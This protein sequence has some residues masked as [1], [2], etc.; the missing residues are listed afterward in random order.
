MITKFVHYLKKRSSEKHVFDILKSN[1]SRIAVRTYVHETSGLLLN[2][3][4]RCG[5]VVEHLHHDFD[6]DKFKNDPNRLYKH[7][8]M[9]PNIEAK[10]TNDADIVFNQT[11]ISSFTII[12][13]IYT[14]KK[15]TIIHV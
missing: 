9:I 8:Y 15:G 3:L 11:G 5:N 4:S 7:V 13:D 6:Y 1:C 12:K 14:K 10:F 2:I